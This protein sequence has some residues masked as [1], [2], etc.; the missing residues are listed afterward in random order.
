[1]QLVSTVGGGQ[2][3]L[4]PCAFMVVLFGDQAVDSPGEATLTLGRLTGSPVTAYSWALSESLH[5][6][7][8]NS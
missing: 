6:F 3:L 8:P 7:F 4:G 2:G 5:R 1:M